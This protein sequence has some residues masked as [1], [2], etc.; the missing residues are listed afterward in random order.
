MAKIHGLIFIL[1]GAII[2]LI[3]YFMGMYFFMFFGGLFMLW[4]ILKLLYSRLTRQKAGT[5]YRTQAQH[6]SHSVHN[7][8]HPHHHAAPQHGQHMHHS[9][10]HPQHVMQHR[11]PYN[12]LCTVCGTTLRPA[13]RY[14]PGCGRPQ[15]HRQV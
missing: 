8:T 1:I 11:E 4:G 15:H 9:Q 10:Q 2:T 6:H 13:D 7:T 5:M 12:R 3:S 14:C